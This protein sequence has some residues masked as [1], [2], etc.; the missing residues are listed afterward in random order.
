MLQ[1][2]RPLPFDTKVLIREIQDEISDFSPVSL[3]RHVAIIPD[4]NRRWAKERARPFL[5]GYLQGSYTLMKTALTAKAL[6]IPLL[7]S[8]TFSTENWKRPY[9]EQ[10]LLWEIFTA[11]LQSYKDHLVESDIKLST[12]GNKESL[13]FE[14]QATIQEVEKATKNS[15]SLHL[16][17]AMNYGGRDEIIRAFKKILS[18]TQKNEILDALDEN[19]FAKHLD[20][21]LWP[22]PDLIIRTGGEQRISNF[23]LW[24]SSYAE[25]YVEKQYWPD[26]SPKNFIKALEDFQKR[27]RRHGGGDA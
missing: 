11:H 10:S 5:E 18:S 1:H 12:I 4:G 2:V 24:Q 6:H 20:T 23:L 25:L 22:D 21:H 8:F 27:S 7:T 16:V 17:L 13:P 9:Q 14:L 3:P 15:S 26:F 19:S